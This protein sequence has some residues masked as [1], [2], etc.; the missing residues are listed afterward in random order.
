[1]EVYYEGFNVTNSV[2]IDEDHM[3]V[4]LE[5]YE[6][7][8]EDEWHKLV[9]LDL[10]T[11]EEKVVIEPEAAVNILDICRIPSGEDENPYFIMHTGKGLQLVNPV[12]RKSYDLA[13]NAQTNFNVCR[14]MSVVPIDPED[15]DQGFWLCQIDNGASMQQ[16]VKAF[17]FK[18]D[19]IAS[20][21]GLASKAQKS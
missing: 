15:L 2:F 10:D 14:S 11:R 20:L 16:V 13:Q 4:S 6:E 21:K 7:E 17:D 19:F 9:I 3:L 18:A 1:M 12:K 5:H 8:T